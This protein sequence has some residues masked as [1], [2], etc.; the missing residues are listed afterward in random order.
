MEPAGTN[1][2]GDE[3]MGKGTTEKHHSRR[4]SSKSCP[5]V[6]TNPLRQALS[7]HTVPRRSRGDGLIWPTEIFCG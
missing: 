4:L 3:K 5:A 2:R 6:I 1:C 7:G